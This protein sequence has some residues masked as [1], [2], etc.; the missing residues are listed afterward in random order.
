M[1]RELGPHVIDLRLVHLSPADG[2]SLAL[3]DRV[4]DHVTIR[5]LLFGSFH[6]PVAMH[7]NQMES[8]EALVDSDQVNSIGETLLLGLAFLA[9]LFQAHSASTLHCVVV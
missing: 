2:A 5:V 7:A 9:E 1:L 3:G 8:V 4:S 6:K